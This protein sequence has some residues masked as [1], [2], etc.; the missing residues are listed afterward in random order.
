MYKL[1]EIE[2]REL[3]FKLEVIMYYLI[4]TNGYAF[5]LFNHPLPYTKEPDSNIIEYMEDI[6]NLINKLKG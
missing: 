3:D 2:I 6:I 5:K 1:D 4:H